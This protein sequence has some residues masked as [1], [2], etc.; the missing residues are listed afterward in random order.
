MA[1]PNP[2][3]DDLNASKD[4]SLIKLGEEAHYGLFKWCNA[5]GLMTQ[6]YSKIKE[7]KH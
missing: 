7:G 2:S 1:A 5:F 3:K 6:G 4:F